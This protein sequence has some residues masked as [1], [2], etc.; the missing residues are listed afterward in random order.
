M[1]EVF[2]K[3]G[4]FWWLDKPNDKTNSKE[5]CIP[6]TLTVSEEGRIE[7]NLDGALWWAE[8]LDPL[9]LGHPRPLPRHKRIT[10][11]LGSYGEGGHVL[12]CGLERTDIPLN[13]GDPQSYEAEICITRT[14]A[15]GV[16]FDLEKFHHLRVPLTGLEDWLELDSIQVGTED[17]YEG[18]TVEVNV[19]YKNHRFSFENAGAKIAIETLT[20]GG[21]SFFRFSDSPTRAVTF[22]QTC[23]LIYTPATES[24][25]SAL[26][27]EFGQIEEF[28]GLLL[29]SYFR[30]DW[31]IVVHGQDE[32]ESWNQ[33]FFFRGAAKQSSL[34]SWFTWTTFHAVQESFGE[35]FFSWQEQREQY[36]PGFYLYSAALRNPLPHWEHSF[37]NLTWALESIHKR[38][39]PGAAQTPSE[40]ERKARIQSIRRILIAA[41]SQEDLKWFEARVPDYQKDPKLA[42]RIFDLLS[43][44]P[45][46]FPPN[47]LSDFSIRCANRR[48]AISHDGGPPEGETYLEFFED[49]QNLTSALSYLYHG[50]LLHE[51]GLDNESLRLAFTKSGLAEM[52]IL[53][54]L[55]RVKLVPKPATGDRPLP[56]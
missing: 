5:T 48:N 38:R 42:D 29:G 32:F 25:L 50:F 47:A 18:D 12:L 15:F 49:L 40:V 9:P 46:A 8:P 17:I 27:Y 36:G 28:L 51:I 22:T 43:M 3:R 24:S 37:V 14:S 2:D 6:G 33:V 55:E 1:T 34:N 20:L 53:P 54:A 35:M 41:D 44:L 7:L 23:N 4:F 30:L 26:C 39:N 19:K 45:I 13:T 16:D 31:P 52:R 56:V 21:G 10:G 11:T